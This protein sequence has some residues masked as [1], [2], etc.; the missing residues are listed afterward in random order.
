MGGGNMSDRIL[1]R[2]QRPAPMRV[3]AKLRTIDETAALLEA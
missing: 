3:V 2:A 1:N